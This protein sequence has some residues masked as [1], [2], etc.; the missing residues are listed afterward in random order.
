[1]IKK[2]KKFLFN[3]DERFLFLDYLGFYR[4]MNDREFVVR[5]YEAKMGRKIDI[6]NPKT[7]NEKLQWLK[8]Y[9]RK[10]DYTKMVDKQ[11][12]KKYV[13]EKIGSKY[14]IETLGVWKKFN[15]INFESLPEQFV[16]KC[17]HD[18]GGLAIC[19]QKETFDVK[20]AKKKI[21]KSLRSSYFYYGREWPYK[22]VEPRIIAE[23][24]LEDE[25]GEELKD[26][27][28][29]CFAGK[30]KLIQVHCG[31][32]KEH[33]QDFY[34]TDWNKLDIY[35][36]TP[37]SEEVMP[38]P[39]FYDEMIALSEILSRDIPQLRVDWYY[40]N[41]QLYFGELTFF[42]ASGYWAFEPNI[43]DE[44]MGEWIELPS[45]TTDIK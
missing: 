33:L 9:D 19:R 17:T 18:S 8:L 12:V 37:Q 1:M 15:E 5:K 24:Y 3:K 38:K 26:Y 27:K 10:S 44:K 34:D 39:V 21:N 23:R 30:A 36:G 2:I 43:W 7:F 13:S 45:K 31:R 42:D 28:V 11:E 41:N 29:M 25:A 4:S 35:Q 22:N 16:I 32:F 20:K 40:T 14:I 6:E